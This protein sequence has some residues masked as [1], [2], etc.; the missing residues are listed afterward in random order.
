MGYPWQPRFGESAPYSEVTRAFTGDR[1]E[2]PF[3]VQIPI[4]PQVEHS[5]VQETKWGALLGVK[6]GSGVV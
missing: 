5:R 4:S 2:G 1:T 6:G 3:Q